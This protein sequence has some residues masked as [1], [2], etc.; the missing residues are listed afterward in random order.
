[1]ASL[2]QV[3]TVTAIIAFF[4]AGVLIDL[5]RRRGR[6]KKKHGGWYDRDG[7]KLE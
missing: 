2:A 7:N 4:T 5:V 6:K 3:L 1:M